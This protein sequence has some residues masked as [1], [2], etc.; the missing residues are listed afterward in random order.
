LK[1]VADKRTA[2]F[3]GFFDDVSSQVSTIY[4]KLSAKESNLGLGGSAQ[5]YLDDR[6]TPFDKTMHYYPCPPDKRNVYDIS[7]LSGGEKTVAALALLFAMIQVKRPPLLLLD[8]V[9][10]F[11]DVQNV[12]LVTDFVRNE[13]VTQTLMVSHK[14]HV[15]KNAMSLIGT[16]FIKQQKTSKVYSLDLRN[17]SE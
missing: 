3:L 2:L 4:Q 7:Q 16:S 6:V 13:L 1:L 14:E 11:L 9:D 8:E 15:V 17:Y 12:N 5:L 10:A